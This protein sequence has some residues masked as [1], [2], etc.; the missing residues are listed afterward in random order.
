MKRLS[1]LTLAL[2]ALLLLFCGC[3]S[4]GEPSKEKRPLPDFVLPLEGDRAY[5]IVRSETA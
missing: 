5:V 1:A 3:E 2:F 4:G